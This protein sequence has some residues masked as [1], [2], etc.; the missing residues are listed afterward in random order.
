MGLANRQKK[1]KTKPTKQSKEPSRRRQEE[2]S[3]DL[4]VD[5][6]VDRVSHQTMVFISVGAI[7]GVI[8]FLAFFFSS[9]ISQ[10]IAKAKSQAARVSQTNTSQDSVSTPQ[11]DSESTNSFHIAVLGDT[12]TKE[13]VI[14]YI[15]SLS[16]E[17]FTSLIETITTN[18]EMDDVRDSKK[19]SELLTLLIQGKL[20]AKSD[21]LSYVESMSDDDFNAFMD[22]L[23]KA[24]SSE[25]LDSLYQGIHKSDVSQDD[26]QEASTEDRLQTSLEDAYAEAEALYPGQIDGSKRLKLIEDLNATDYMYYVAEQGDTLIKLSNAFGVSLGQLVELNGIHDADKVDAGE[27][28]LFPS[29]T[30]QPELDSDNQ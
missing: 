9:D 17:D 13:D 4:V 2:P 6:Q 25:Q 27:I 22:A 21:V 26:N 3:T 10:N 12:T 19:S 29:D 23:V 7:V 18:V 24:V 28:L 5:E 8:L 11:T 15:D 20:T 1:N 14:A 16:D 30:V